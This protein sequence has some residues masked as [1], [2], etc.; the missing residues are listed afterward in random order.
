[1][2]LFIKQKYLDQ[3]ESGAK[4]YEI[5]AGSRYRNVKVGTVLSLNG[6][7]RVTVTRVEVHFT[8]T[9]LPVD[10]SDCYPNATGPFYVF[11]F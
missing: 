11:H 10:V 2:L 4:R 6:R 5:R 3:I 1:M 9:T 7:K 8:A